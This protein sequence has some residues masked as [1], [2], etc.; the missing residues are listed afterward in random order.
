MASSMSDE[1]DKIKHSKRLSK[2]IAAEKR[3]ARIAKSH[4]APVPEDEL[5]RYSKHHAMDCGQTGCVLCG[6]PRHNK[7][8]KTKDKLTIQEK[9]D[10]QKGLDE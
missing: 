1:Q 5:H 3:Q 9:R 8:F 2:E 10:S 7:A 6:N 4:G